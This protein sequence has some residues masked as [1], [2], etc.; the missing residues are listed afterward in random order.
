MAPIS[1]RLIECLGND[2]QLESRATTMLEI[3]RYEKASGVSMDFGF[4]I[5]RWVVFDKTGIQVFSPDTSEDFQL[6]KAHT[7]VAPKPIDWFTVE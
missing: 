7:C 6:W 1:E 4:W 3:E 2:A 5:Y